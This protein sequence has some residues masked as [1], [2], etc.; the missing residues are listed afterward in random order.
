MVL[1]AMNDKTLSRAASILGRKG[2]KATVLKNTSEQRV[3]L[4]RK[5]ISTRWGKQRKE[6]E[7]TQSQ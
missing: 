2:G 3:A 5:A 6:T 4:A 1:S 7:D